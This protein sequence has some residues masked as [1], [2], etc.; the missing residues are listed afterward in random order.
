M[1]VAIFS[2]VYPQA[3][4]FVC[5]FLDSLAKQTDKNFSLFLIN[6]GLADI[7][8]YLEKFDF[9]VQIKDA[10]GLI[11]K[12]RK[13]G[14]DWVV[15]KGAEEI[16]FADSDDYFENT[17]VE[18]SK[19][20]LAHHDIIFNELY[21]V[22][23]EISEPTLMFDKYFNNSMEIGKKHVLEGNCM[24]MSNTA[25]HTRVIPQDMASIPNDIIAFDWAFFS[26]CIQGGARTVFTNET[27][28]YY[29]Q[30]GN[31][32]AAPQCFSEK[33]IMRG[34]EV[35]RDHY[36]FLSRFDKEY[37]S[38]AKTFE[39]LFSRLNSDGVL[40][41]KYCQTVKERASDVSLWWEPIKTLEELGL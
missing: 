27:K 21:L 35:K 17:R 23:P 13:V 24:G 40:K 11:A 41:R 2:V 14:I 34:V 33:Q 19:R 1:D 9:N 31:N 4:S 5:E 37:E 22:G 3:E 10:S 7:E 25:L 8:K 16:I 32:T 38:L 15:S 29:R 36:Q 30:H 20:M 18:V 12:L 39:L 6:D 26:M 28:T